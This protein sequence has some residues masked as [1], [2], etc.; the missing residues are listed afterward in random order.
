[1]RLLDWALWQLFTLF[2]ALFVRASLF[3]EYGSHHG[4]IVSGI[5]LIGAVTFAVVAGTVIP[6]RRWRAA[7]RKNQSSP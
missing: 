7:D 3:G 4:A 1:M 6:L 2:F 5:A